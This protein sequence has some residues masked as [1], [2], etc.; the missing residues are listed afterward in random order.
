MSLVY[1]LINVNKVN[2]PV[3]TDRISY[4]IDNNNN[5]MY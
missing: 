2:I 4:F 5:I 1:R 3:D